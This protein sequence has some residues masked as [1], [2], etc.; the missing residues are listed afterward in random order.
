MGFEISRR[1]GVTGATAAVAV[2][3]L[4]ATLG[5]YAVGREAS[6]AERLVEHFAEA[7]DN[8]D[9]GG[10]ASLT[11]YPNAASASIQQIFDGLHPESVDYKVSQFIGLDEASGFF[12]LDAVWDFGRDRNWTY[13]VS[14]SVRKL[15]VGWRISWEPS[16]VMPELGHSR[17]VNLVRTDAAAPRVVDATGAVLMDE[18]TINAIKL[19]PAHMPDPVASTTAL[20][21]AIEPVAPLITSQSLLEDLVVAQ[22]KSITAVTLRDADFEILEPELSPIPGVVLEKQPKLIATDRR[23][24][25]PVLDGL[26]NVWQA[27]RDAT[28][29]WAVRISE[30]GGGEPIQMAGFQGPPGPDVAATLDPK[31]QLAAEDA[32]VSVGT[33]ATIVAIQPSTGAVLAV[34]QNSYATD[35]GPISLT[36][37]FP[38]GSNLEL[39]RDAAA[40]MKGVAP[41]DVSASDILDSASDLGIGVDFD[42]PGLDEVTGSLPGDGSGMEGIRERKPKSDAVMV[43]PFGMAVVSASIARGAPTAPMIAYGQPGTPDTEQEPLRADMVERLRG[44][45]RDAAKNPDLESL[46]SM[47]DVAA[48]AASNGGD[49]WLIGNRGDL[50]FAVFIQDADGSDQAAK[51]TTRMFRALSKPQP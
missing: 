37:L 6:E 2:A 49:Q 14:G 23:V 34:A 18:Q 42:V 7:L 41:S 29:G 5:S 9:V 8:Q 3:A 24:V 35:I 36:G 43:S 20:A 48:Y 12:T 15:A 39:F 45:M 51:M 27:N 22:G 4:V 13:S 30:R 11:S 25:S 19:D 21:K 1:V 44:L 33:P 32:V 50:A 16:V 47:P 17:A 28:S 40:A 26:R 38:A 31:L 46:R 10:A